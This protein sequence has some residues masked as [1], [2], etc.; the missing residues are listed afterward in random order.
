MP[1]STIATQHD[2]V[3]WKLLRQMLQ[4]GIHPRRVAVRKDEKTGFTWKDSKGVVYDI[5]ISSKNSCYI[6]KT[7]KKTGK[8]YRQYLPKEVSQ[9]IASE[10]G[11]DNT[12][13]YE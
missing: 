11:R 8:Q 6:L 5:Y 1:G 9:Q 10:L 3:L 12:V 13:D 7:S 2:P 4:E